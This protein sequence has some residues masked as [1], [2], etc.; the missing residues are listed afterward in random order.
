M[1]LRFQK[2]VSILPGLR[3]NLGKRGP[4]LS[5]GRRGAWFT[6]GSRGT[7]A[8]VGIPGTGISWTE[9][10]KSKHARQLLAPTR[11]P[12]LP[13][14]SSSVPLDQGDTYGNVPDAEGSEAELR[15]LPASKSKKF[16]WFCVAV[17]LVSFLLAA[18][19]LRVS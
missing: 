2:R 8:T 11:K 18:M 1:G 7:R 16:A 5:I 9:S 14:A 13:E 3:L 15:P 17:F 12:T 19:V 4:S 6:I 10:S